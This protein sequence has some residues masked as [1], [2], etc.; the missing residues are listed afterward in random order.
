MQTLSFAEKVRQARQLEAVLEGFSSEDEDAEGSLDAAAES[1]S[2]IALA[3]TAR[4]AAKAAVGAAPAVVRA[5][6][7]SAS[8]ASTR[9]ESASASVPSTG[10]SCTSILEQLVARH[11]MPPSSSL[12]Q[13]LP[14]P[15]SAA[16]SLLAA[17]GPGSPAS[18]SGSSAN[19]CS[20]SRPRRL[21]PLRHVMEYDSAEEEANDEQESDADASTLRGPRSALRLRRGGRSARSVD[22]PP[23]AYAY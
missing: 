11:P 13:S 15:S 18:S 3:R 17:G 21:P 23:A 8:N 2:H 9:L 14:P 4:A 1:P 5:G 6:D 20:P 16:S 12:S 19:E 7:E 22:A 10:S